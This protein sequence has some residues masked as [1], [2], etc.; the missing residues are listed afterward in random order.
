[1]AF[2]ENISKITAL[3][4]FSIGFLSDSSHF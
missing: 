2:E 4:A 1:M 3:K